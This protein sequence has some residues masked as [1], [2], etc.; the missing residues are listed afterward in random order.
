MKLNYMTLPKQFYYKKNRLQQVRGFCYVVQTGSMLK[1]AQKMGLTQGA[2]TLLVQSLERDLGIKLFQRNGRDIKPTKEGEMFYHHAILSLQKMDSLFE[3]FAQSNSEKKLSSIGVGGN[4]IIFHILPKYIKKF[5]DLYP[6]VDFKIKNLTRPDAVK[7]VIDGELDVA[8][9]S[10]MPDQIPSELDFIPIVK[11][12]PILLTHKDH[13]LANKKDLVLSDIKPYK[14]L[15]LDP[16]FVTV[17]NFDAVASQHG[18]ETTIEFEMA[19]Y[20]IIKKF[21]KADVGVA[22]VSGICLENEADK[23]LVGRDLSQYF[24]VLTYGMM[25]KKNTIITGLKKEFIEMMQT[26]KLLEAQKMAEG[27]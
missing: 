14:L 19:N 18:L 27:Y 9:Y 8:I 25:I 13:P 10:M 26:E 20:E 2:I 16:Q 6:H 4:I 21:V 12:S 17:P 7:R 15:R 1:C 22:I 3:S 5:E 23:D 11:Y 24:P